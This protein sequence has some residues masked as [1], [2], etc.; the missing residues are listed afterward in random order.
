MRLPIALGLLL[1]SCACNPGDQAQRRLRSQVMEKVRS[2]RPGIRLEEME[3]PLAFRATP[4]GS[5]ASWVSDLDDLWIL[6]RDEN[7]QCEAQI[8]RYARAVAPAQGAWK[9]EQIL[10]TIRDSRTLADDAKTAGRTIL[11]RP[12]AGD[13]SVVYAIDLPESVALVTPRTAHELKLTDD[14]LHQLALRNLEER[15]V[16]MPHEPIAPGSSVFVL[17]AGDA[18]DAGRLALPSRWAALAK[19]VAGDLLVA[20]PARDWVVFTGSARPADVATL[21][22]VAR[23]LRERLDHPLTDTIL[24]WKSSRWEPVP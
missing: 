18:Y 21:R 8:D 16:S 24:R 23:R 19:E 13:L 22:A 7:V 4:A 6:C 20:A 15:V 12:L 17:H 10:A 9:R 5:D 2:Q 14:E 11:H 3:R 1:L